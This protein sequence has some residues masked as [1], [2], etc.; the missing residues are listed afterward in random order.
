MRTTIPA[1]LLL[2][3]CAAG[4]RTYSAPSI[5]TG[6]D[7]ALEQTAALGYEPVAGGTNDGYVRVA[8]QASYTAGDVAKEAAARV[9]TLGI[10]GSNRVTGDF[11]TITNTSNVLR[12]VATG[13]DEQNRATAPSKEAQSHAVSLIAACGRP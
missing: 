5:S 3:S 6:L 8:R 12:I 10:K 11:L 2:A 13:R 7:C 1:L 4:P 9:A